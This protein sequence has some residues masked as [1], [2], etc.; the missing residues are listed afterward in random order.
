MEDWLSNRR[1][2][3]FLRSLAR[4]PAIEWSRSGSE[5]LESDEE[6]KEA[7]I[8]GGGGLWR[9]FIRDRTLGKAGAPDFGQLAIEYK[10]LS[11][12]DIARLSP[13]AKEAT[14]VHKNRGHAC[15]SSFGPGSR[16]VKRALAHN[17]ATHG[18][19]LKKR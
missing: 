5:H 12:L 19:T 4:S 14:T 2:P 9:A 17:K 3:L 7:P 6:H 11:D 10:T 13:I 8:N 16:D 18:H 15:L 1:L